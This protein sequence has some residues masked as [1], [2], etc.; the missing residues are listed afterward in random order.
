[1]KSNLIN[2]VSALIFLIILVSLGC[3][4]TKET[5]TDDGLDP[6]ERDTA[7]ISEEDL[8]ELRTLL[9]QNRSRLSDVHTSQHHDMPEAFLKKDSSDASI[10][11]NPFDG[12]RVQIISTRD[13]QLADSVA[14]QFRTWAD[15][16]IT[17]YE[18][19]TYVSFR[20][21]FYKVHIGDFHQRDQANSFSKLI[22]HKYPDAWVV[23]DRIEPSNTPADTATFQIKK[24]EPLSTDS[25]NTENN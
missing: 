12:Y 6:A 3:T 7:A 21:P 18:A 16:T 15:T 19:K 17:G 10:N 9:T 5:S 25:L 4:A 22:K 8:N 23:H 2:A 20:Q 1:M 11:S 24:P 13:V 14:S